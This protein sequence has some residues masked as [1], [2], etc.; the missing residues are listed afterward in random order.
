M[1]TELPGTNKLSSLLRFAGTPRFLVVF[2]AIWAAVVLFSGIGYGDLSGYDDAVYAHEAREM[3]QSGD[4]WTLHLNGQPDFDKPPLFIWLVAL[5]FKIFGISDTSA[6]VPG[7]LLGWATVLLVY[8]LT[9]EL[10]GEDKTDETTR[11]WLPV[12]SMLCMATTQYFLKNAGHVMTDVPFTFFFT[13]AIYFYVRGLRNGIYLCAAGIGAGLSLLTRSPVGVFPAVIIFIDVVINRRFKTIRSSGFLGFVILSIAIPAAWYIA[14]YRL[15]GELFITRHFGN[16]AEHSQGQTLRSGPQQ[17]FWY[18]EY[19]FLIVRLYIPWFPLMF[20]GIYLA[21]NK[22]ITRSIRAE[23]LIFIWLFVTIVPLSFAESKVLR[24]ILPAFPAFSVLAATS[25]L[26]MFSRERLSRFSQVI[27]AILSVAAL[28][29]IF[30]PHYKLR[31]VD[32]RGIARI[33]DSATLPGENILLFTGGD[34][35]W[36]V[37]NQL[38]WYGHRNTVLIDKLA[39]IETSGTGVVVMD[40]PTFDSMQDR[41]AHNVELLGESP[42][43]VCYRLTATAVN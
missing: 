31:A 12:L 37:Q 40:R 6:K 15:F 16:I 4:V 9:K 32:M 18:F 20:Y 1:S 43:Y 19:F 2:I 38:L 14:E 17:L 24:Y 35:K 41:P 34:L 8:F 22:G 42:N 30:Q 5:S 25:L 29:V 26:H 7:A 11:E 39:N 21:V 27:F 36:D 10:Y 13:A 28:F 33:T 3:V 23:A